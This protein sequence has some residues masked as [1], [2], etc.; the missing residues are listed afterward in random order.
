MR[1]HSPLR[2]LLLCAL[3]LA[4]TAGSARANGSDDRIVQDCQHSASGSLTG[5]YT[6][7]QLRHAL[8]NLPGDVLEYSGCYDAIQQ[9]MIAGAGGRSSGSGGGSGSGASGSGSGTGSSG[10][11]SI[12]GSDGA[13]STAGS[14]GTV[15]S[16]PPPA[17]AEQPQRVAG[18]AV[19]P[20]ALPEIGRDA[21]K[22]PT[23][24]LVL[25]ILLG[26]A[27]LVPA[28]LTIGRRVVAHRSS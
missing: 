25:L 20:G 4:F 17:G 24:L 7:A 8:H 14:T 11:G 12:G 15:P 10:L 28:G 21:H 26:V 6:K 13:G 2:T 1:I 9:A 22:L 5:S 3:L 27:A 23:P 18:A 16:A 19:V